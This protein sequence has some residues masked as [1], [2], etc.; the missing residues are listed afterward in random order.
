M[1]CHAT[2]FGLTYKQVRGWFVERRRREK[3]KNIASELLSGRNGLGIAA[4]RV[5]KLIP[6]S[7]RT[8]A[9]SSLKSKKKKMKPNHIQELQNPDYLLKRVFRKDGPP[10]GV[11]FDSLPSRALWH[12]T[13]T[14][15]RNT[16]VYCTLFKK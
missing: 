14:K 1:E 2:V 6:S 12:S 5:A 3:R 7:H 9:P 13:G 10:L 4:T 16:Q 11:E 8:K 15:M